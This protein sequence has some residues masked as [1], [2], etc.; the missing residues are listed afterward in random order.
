MQPTDGGAQTKSKSSPAVPKGAAAVANHDLRAFPTLA[1][2]KGPKVL[3]G[4]V[5]ERS[6]E[7]GGKDAEKESWETV[8]RGK[9]KEPMANDESTV[10]PEAAVEINP[11]AVR[12]CMHVV[13][14]LYRSTRVIG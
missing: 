13:L 2:S 3:K 5:N 9:K 10:S 14:G 11:N 7:G 8:T 4:P 1:E 6:S 12:D